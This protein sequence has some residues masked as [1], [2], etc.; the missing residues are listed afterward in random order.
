LVKKSTDIVTVSKLAL[1]RYQVVSA[2]S[3]RVLGGLSLS[4]AIRQVLALVLPDH[5]GSPMRMSERTVYRWVRAFEKEGLAGLEPEPHAAAEASSALSPDLLSFIRKHKQ[6][7]E[8]ASVPELIRQARSAGV[9]AETEPVS[10]VTLWRACRRLG[11]SLRRAHRRAARDMRRFAFPNR[12]LCV[13]ADGKHFRAGVTRAKRVALFLLDDATRKA[14]GVAVGTS[15]CTE[16]FLRALHQV[17]LRFGLMKVLF[18]DHGPGFVSDDTRTVVARLGVKLVWGAEGYPEGHG[19]I[20]RFNRTAKARVLRSLPGRVEI[21]PAPEVLALRL[22][23]WSATDYNCSPHEGLGGI[24]PDQ[25]WGQDPRGLEYPPSREWLDSRFL[26]T[27]SRRVSNDNVIPYESTDFEVPR[28]YAGSRIT[29][30]RHILDHDRLT[31]VHHGREVTLKPVDLAAN[32][33]AR[34]A[35]KATDPDQE[36][37][38]ATAA[39][40]AFEQ[41]L[42]PIVSPDGDFPKGEHDD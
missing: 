37:P 8:E 35:A 41:D 33:Y 19:K 17:V 29:V 6:E 16:L 4:V 28:G 42:G 27:F 1:D 15:E 2:V 31:V 10:R 22:E 12:M 36:T 18:V 13:L 11:L 25:R 5:R 7:D 40:A 38:V 21:D 14:L 9:L 34:R 30:T 26:L 39:S 20:E 23:H 32:A 3:T 24:S